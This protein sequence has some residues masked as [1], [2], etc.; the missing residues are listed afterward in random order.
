MERLLRIWSPFGIVEVANA[1]FPWWCLVAVVSLVWHARWLDLVAVAG[2]LYVLSGAAFMQVSRWWSRQLGL[3]RY[4]VVPI[5]RWIAVALV[6]GRLSLPRGRRY[7]VLHVR[8]EG[9]LDPRQ[10]AQ[11]MQEDVRKAMAAEW[12]RGAVFLG[13]TFADLGRRQKRLLA[14]YGEVEMV[15]GTFVPGQ[16]WWLNP[17]RYQKHMFGRVFGGGQW[18]IVKFVVTRPRRCL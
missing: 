10:M 8:S 3:R 14:Q 16:T 12:T 4:I 5:P 18:K 7:F 11:E 2:A 15:P 6:R 9:G 13:C 17:K 1:L